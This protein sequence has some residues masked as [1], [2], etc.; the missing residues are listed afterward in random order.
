LED[1]EALTGISSRKEV[2]N[3]KYEKPQ[4]AKAGY[5]ARAI[6]GTKPSGRYAD[7]N[8]TKSQTQFAY[9]ADE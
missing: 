8:P 7:M 9:E 4:I 2:R 3:M 6:Q 5:A 1:I